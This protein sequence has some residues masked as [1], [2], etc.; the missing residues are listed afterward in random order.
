[1]LL[2]SRWQFGNILL[3]SSNDT[4]GFV[5][6]IGL[7]GVNIVFSQVSLIFIATSFSSIFATSLLTSFFAPFLVAQDSNFLSRFYTFRTPD[8]TSYMHPHVSGI[9]YAFS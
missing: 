4:I 1:M 7:E 6:L 5:A 3:L 2:N 9:L 8:T